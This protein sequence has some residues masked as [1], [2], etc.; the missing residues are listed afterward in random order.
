MKAM[1]IDCRPFAEY[2]LGHQYGACSL[3]ATELFARMHELPQRSQILS[4]CGKTDD[5]KLAA[6]YL[7][8]RGYTVA[9]HIIWSNGLQKQLAASGELETGVSSAQLWQP[10][11]LWRRFAK[12]IVPMHSI[13]VG[14]GLDIG[15]GAGRD[16]IYLA[17][18]GWQMTGVD[19]S[20]DSLQRVALLAK[21]TNVNVQT[22]QRDLEPNDASDPLLDVADDSFDLITVARYLHRPLFPVIKRLLRPGG[23][24]MYQTFMQ[25]CEQTTIGRP[26]NPNFLLRPAELATEFGAGEIILDTVET[27]DDGR[28][29]AAFVA[30]LPL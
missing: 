7:L 26:R 24:L 17:Q 25:G 29:V 1:L 9:E 14:R 21:Q 23:I 28:P 11:P 10:A 13:E 30:R 4:L 8:N 6:D 15:C 22:L 2:R 5:L 20:A 16:M 19:R 12:E 18:Q 3:P 27:L